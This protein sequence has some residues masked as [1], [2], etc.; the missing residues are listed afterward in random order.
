MRKRIV[1]A[2]F[3]VICINML[4]Y[5]VDAWI[6]INQLGYLPNAQKKA[7][8]I[9]ESP[10]T[11]KQFT[12]HD[13]LTNK[14]L[15]T[16]NTV[17]SWGKFQSYKSTYI[18]DFSSFHLQGAFYIKA[19]LIFSP[20]IFV[21]KNIYLG[22]ADF[23]LN[24]IRQQRCGYN[25]SLKAVCHEDDGYEIY[26]EKSEETTSTKKTKSLKKNSFELE[27]LFPK[28]VDVRGG[29]HDGSDYLKYGA[30]TS[31]A[32]FQLLFAYQMNPTAFSD[33]HDAT[34]DTIKNGIPDILDE[35]KWG[36]DW[37]IKMYP[38]K[39]VL[40][41]QVA[42]DRDN[43]GLRLP[44]EDPVDYGWG[45]RT[46]RPVY[47]AA[48][49]PQG[50]FSFKNHSTGIASIAGKYASS[51]ALGAEVLRD[52][53]PAF[54]DSLTAKAVEAYQYGQNNPGVC[55]SVPCKS[56]YFYEEEN[57]TDD[58]EL[59]ATQ[60]YRLTYNNSYLKEATGYGRMEPITPWM[61]SDT[62][63]H[64][65]W[66]PFLN[67]GH[68]MLT[69][70]ENPRYR[71]EFSQNMLTGIQRISTH[72]A[73]NP[74]NVGVPQILCSNNLITAMATQCKLYRTT[75]KD[76]TYLGMETSLIDWLFGC[77]PWGKS[78]IVG[79]PKIGD[80][81]SDPHSALWHNQKIPVLGGLVNGPVSRGIYNS[82]P[83][84]NLSKK[85]IYARFQTDWAV[86]HDDYADYTTNEPTLDGTAA[87]SYLLSCKQVEGVSQKTSDNNEY[88][89][90][91]ITRTDKNKKQIT[92]IFSGNDY[93]DGSKIICK[94]LKKL[95]IKASFF[96]TGNF[97]RNSKF[98]KTIEELQK[99]NHYL[100]CHS[101]KNLLYCSLQQ[102]DTVLISKNDFLND[103]NN[104]YKSMEK[105]GIQKNDAPFFLPPYEWYNDSISRWSKE[106]GVNLI[107]YTPGTL[108]NCDSSIP[109]M[110]NNYYSSAEI[111]NQIMN[112]E[113][114]NGLNGYILLFHIGTD[115]R[116]QD[117]FYP[118][119]YNL[120]IELSRAGYDF[121]DLYKATDV[122]DKNPVLLPDEKQKRKN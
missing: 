64:Y 19:G 76:S 15:A 44:T 67:L 71:K 99:D 25:P 29:W 63:S 37:L 28:F 18:L 110:R 105:F 51:F 14:E 77:N 12:I 117:K 93:A 92:L 72:A 11:I 101:D 31:N 89:Y 24:Y 79:L 80:T 107:N 55:Q 21:N 100:G 88:A 39:D 1:L 10:Q 106:V 59:A 26:A 122:V 48:G 53:Y 102:R 111:Y 6:R 96:F 27:S 115:K 17:T 116:R 9:S 56:P 47:L 20:T 46:G 50:L 90:G 119:L 121:V 23:L 94:T 16:L 81:P 58:M 114:R 54:V 62:A 85:D 95:N 22:S 7:I 69:N 57:W 82:F 75:T 60:L 43:T 32:I 33:I 45:S 61:C 68:Y 3:S 30:T 113:R 84:N 42:D 70:I 5:G 4:T 98:K 103:L 34:G 36:L 13:A 73:E 109:E 97:Y 78:M 120:L 74:F 35:A 108:S 112:L 66:Y 49:K 8:F 118:Q 52:F 104:N 38:S 87:L 86:Y 91:G 83:N 2:C 40:Y 65:E 41:H